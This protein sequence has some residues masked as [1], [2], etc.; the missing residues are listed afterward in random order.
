[1][2][3]ITE[4]QKNMLWGWEWPYSEAKLIFET[5]ILDNQIS[6]NFITVEATINPT[7]FEICKQNI[8]K[9]SKNPMISQLLEHSD[10]RWKKHWY[11]SMA[12]S[13]PYDRN[14]KEDEIE[15]LKEAKLNLSYT[16]KAIIDMHNF[17]IKFLEI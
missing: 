4:Q 11:I 8:D 13:H 2:I 10:Y 5:R 1:M 16:E 14:N 3:K 12:F 6:R 17:I 15:I 9:F 7:T